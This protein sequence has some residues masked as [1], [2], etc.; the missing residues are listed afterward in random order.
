MVACRNS[1]V[2]GLTFMVKLASLSFYSHNFQSFMLINNQG[3]LVI[4]NGL[5]AHAVICTYMDNKKY[6]TH[7][8]LKYALKKL[9]HFV[10]Y[11]HKVFCQSLWMAINI[12]I[13]STGLQSIHTK[14][15]TITI[16]PRLHP[17]KKSPSPEKLSRYL[18][19]LLHKT[20]QFCTVVKSFTSFLNL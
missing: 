14:A 16:N 11:I 20:S 15:N 10:S 6:A 9:L 8:T 5:L 4:M 13:C 3:L 18:L 12:N 1:G 2:R 17:K 19:I 7:I